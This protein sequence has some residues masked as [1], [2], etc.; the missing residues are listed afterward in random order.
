[1]DGSLTGRLTLRHNV[2]EIFDYFERTAKR[3]REAEQ[4]DTIKI[5]KPVITTVGGA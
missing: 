5:A 2:L 4:S 1:M 3:D